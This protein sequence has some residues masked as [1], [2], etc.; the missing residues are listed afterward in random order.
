MKSV[1]ICVCVC[2]WGGGGEVG[3]SLATVCNIYSIYNKKFVKISHTLN[4]VVCSRYFYNH[5]NVDARSSKFDLRNP[6]KLN[7]SYSFT[8]FK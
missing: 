6:P 5:R 3:R 4:V 7:R 8:K 1:C 2:V